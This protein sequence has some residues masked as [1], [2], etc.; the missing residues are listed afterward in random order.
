MSTPF[1]ASLMREKF[2]LRDLAGDLSDDPPIIALSNRISLNLEGNGVHESYVIRTQNMHSCVRLCAAIHKEF[3]DFGSIAERIDG[4]NWDKM[5]QDVTKGFERN[6]NPDIWGCIYQNGKPVFTKG[7]HH[8]F[9][10]IIEQCDAKEKGDYEDSVVFAEKAFKQAGKNMKIEHDANIALILKILPEEAKCGLIIRGANRTT[11][12]NYTVKVHQRHNELVRVATIMSVSA[13]FLEGI[14]LAFFV[15]MSNKKDELD[16]I[17][18]HSDEYR[19]WK[20]ATQRL[21]S[22]NTAISQFEMKY[23]VNYRPERPSFGEIIDDSEKF[24]ATILKPQVAEQITS[25]EDDE[26]ITL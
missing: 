13:A 11:T 4:F 16:M 9:L 14:Q 10:D 7:E 22:L 26:E 1:Q 6:W 25:E 17:E 8:P 21:G 12:F 23:D 19:K 20:K 18:A 15:G 24:A 3:M 2:I 5:W